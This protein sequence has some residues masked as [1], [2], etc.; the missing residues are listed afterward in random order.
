[1]EEPDLC[2]HERARHEPDRDPSASCQ[3]ERQQPD[4]VLRREDL[5][6]GEKAG[7][8]G[9]ERERQLRAEVARAR[10]QPPDRHDCE[11]LERQQAGGDRVGRAAREV[12]PRDAEGLDDTR[13]V[14]TELV[15]HEQERGTEALDLQPTRRLRV[16]ALVDAVG[17]VRGERRDHG[18]RDEDEHPEAER[19]TPRA[20]P[21]PREPER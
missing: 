2:E 14:E 15:E 1:V 7:D 17:R 6:E 18:R 8:R 19:S 11:R 10:V 20:V 13:V 4:E 3:N 9:R 12:P 5:R 21:P 16:E